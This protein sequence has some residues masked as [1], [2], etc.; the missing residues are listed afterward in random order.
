MATMDHY[1]NG[2]W[3]G[4]TQVKGHSDVTGWVD[5]YMADGTV[6]QTWISNTDQFDYKEDKY[7]PYR[8]KT[9]EEIQSEN[10][11]AHELGELIGKVWP[12]IMKFGLCAVG[13]MVVSAI[14]IFA[15]PMFG[16]ED[17]NI[18]Y[19]ITFVVDGI[20]GFISAVIIV[21]SE[22]IKRNKKKG[23]RK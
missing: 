1:E 19:L 9:I 8:E 23:K 7:P 20:F 4:S 5:T 10:F 2:K 13:I 16:I 21:L 12:L 11:A 18:T 22:L 15:L 14:V 17:K 3:V 6:R